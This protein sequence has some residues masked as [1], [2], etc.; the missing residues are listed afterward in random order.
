[1]LDGWAVEWGNFTASYVESPGGG[2]ADSRQ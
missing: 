2:E 1:M